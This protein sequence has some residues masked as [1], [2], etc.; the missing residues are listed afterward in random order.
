[1]PTSRLTCLD[2]D[3]PF[4]IRR[5]P[6]VARPGAGRNGTTSP[7]RL[8][9]GAAGSARAAATPAAA[10]SPARRPR[11]VALSDLRPDASEALAGSDEGE[12]PSQL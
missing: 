10:P 6:P 1:M 3:D 9:D 12:A 11:G 7:D 4:G 8:A 5:R 2:L